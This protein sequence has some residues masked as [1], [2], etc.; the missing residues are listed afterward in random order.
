MDK[1]ELHIKALKGPVLITGASGFVGSNLLRVLLKVRKDVFAA[2]HQD[3]NWRLKDINEDHLFKVDFNDYS[4]VKNMVAELQPQTIFDCAAFGAYAHESNSELIYQTNFLAKMNF[5]NCLQDVKVSAYVH[6]GSSSEYGNNSSAPSEL[7]PFLPN[8]DYSVSK[9]AISQYLSFIGKHKSFPCVNLR[10][11]SVYGQYEDTS[12]LIPK[13]VSMALAGQYPPFVDPEVSRDFV[14][15]D[16]AVSAFILSASKM[17]PEIYGESFNI[18]TGVKTTISDLAA[19][20][21]KVFKLDASAEFQTMPNRQWDTS[22]WFADYEK[23]YNT[24]G[25]KAS[26]NLSDGLLLTAKWIETLRP[27]DFLHT[28]NLNSITKSRSI[29]AIVACYKDNLAIPIMYERLTSTFQR[30]GIDY[31]IILVNDGS[32]DDTLQ[33]I[34]KI[35]SNDHRVLGITHSRNFGSQMAFRSGMEMATK[36][37]VVLLDGD[38]QD[39]PELIEEFYKK[40]MDGY[41]I[42]YGSRVKRDMPRYLEL[43]YKGFYRIFSKF[44]Y[45]EIPLDAGDFSLIDKRAMKWILSSPERDLFMRGIR[46]YVGF[47]QTGVEYIRPERLF[48]NST[49]NLM[50]NL[51]WAKKGIFSFSNVPLT[52]LTSFGLFA[53]L[54]SVGLA[55]A[56]AI[57]QIVNPAIAPKG[58]TTLL[59]LILL[60]GSVNIFAIGLVGEYVGKIMLEVKQRPRLIRSA[61]TRNG[62]TVTDIPDGKLVYRNSSGS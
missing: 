59:I 8:S 23:T 29:T 35:S 28:T 21:K 58:V 54:S 40:W 37:A 56:S 2:I 39:P 51:E 52:V 9:L 53:L 50:K 27:E 45:V 10:L 33:V 14:H 36:D 30:L 17:N 7:G 55:I 4:S 25:W 57:L 12:R 48:G 60:F 5:I 3:P 42:V 34:E 61:L 16:D 20:A 15:V 13:L 1:F 49:N 19:I 32:P 46:A 22:E 44:S 26:V 18:G 41:E 6:A 47:N 11:Y 38:L 62:T 24:F 31:E 43:L